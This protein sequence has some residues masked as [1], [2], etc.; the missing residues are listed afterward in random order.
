MGIG[1][2]TD[3]RW[4]DFY[5]TAAKTVYPADLDWKSAYTLEFVTPAKTP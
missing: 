3:V 5:E 1:A 4:T 2:M